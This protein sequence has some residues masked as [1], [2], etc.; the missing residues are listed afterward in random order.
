MKDGFCRVAAATPAIRVADVAGNVQEILRLAGQACE[1]GC[2]LVVFPELCL[3]GYSCGDLFYQESLQR[4]ALDGLLTIREESRSL[5]ALLLVGLPFRYQGRLF[6]VAAAVCQG[7]VLGLVPKRFV[8]N[9]GEFYERRYFAEGFGECV[10][11]ELFG[12]TTGFGTDQLFVHSVMPQMSV[13][14]ELCE[15]LWVPVPPS[16]RHAQA[17]AHIIANLSASDE[18][19]GKSD[20]R[21]TLVTGQSARLYAA[22]VYASAGTGESTQD[23][24]YSGHRLISENGRLLAEGDRYSTG[25][26]EADIDLGACVARRQGMTTFAPDGVSGCKRALLAQDGYRRTVFATDCPT[27]SLR[28]RVDRHPFVPEDDEA[29]G[30][31]CQEILAIQSAGLEQRLRHT[32]ARTAVIGISGGLDSTLALLVAVMAF[33]R[34]G[35]ERAGVIGITM[36]GFGTTDRTY[37]NACELVRSLGATLREIPIAAAVRQ[38]FA[39]IGQDEGTHDVTYENAQARERTQI[40]MDVANK[41][42]GLVVGTGDLSELALGW[43]TYNGDHMSMYAVNASVPKTLVRHLVRYYAIRLCETGSVL[44]KVLLDVLDTPVSPELLPPEDG[45]ISQKTEE[46][47][48]P[49]EL[50]DFFLYYLMRF[51]YTPRKIDRLAAAAFAGV[52]DQTTIRKWM[53]VFYRRFFA[54]QFKRSCLPDGPKVGTVALSPRGDWRMPSDAVSDLWLAEIDGLE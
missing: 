31:R 1:D 27:I 39:D 4:A 52:F 22:Y 19:V 41:E 17:G 20:Y 15:D 7:S 21:R 12:E 48:G 14:C 33:D 34:L 43:A 32:R 44:Q 29:L 3:T 24:V 26:T 16:G 13:A 37:D 8:P 18:L 5:D 45:V 9:Y 6:N 38:H 40:L 46:L 47:V 23:V 53:R 51:G 25:L 28:R 54:Q 11:V 35:W 2:K 49:Y 10:E 50:H 42:N 30:G 36:P